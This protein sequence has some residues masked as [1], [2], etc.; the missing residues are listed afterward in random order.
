MAT[1]NPGMLDTWYDDYLKT[2]PTATKPEQAQTTSWN[3]DENQTVQGQLK[4]MLNSGSPL[5]KMAATRAEQQA[6]RRG[7]QGSSMA[8]QA[9]QAA[10]Y[11]AAVPIAT[12]DAATYGRAGEVNATQANETSRFNTGQANTWNTADADRRVR[13]IQVGRELAQQESQFSRNMDLEGRKLDQQESQF[14]RNLT[15]QGRQADL[16]ANTQLKVAGMN[17]DIEDKRLSV[18]D[19]QFLQTLGLEQRKLDDSMD[20]FAKRLGLDRA[21]LDLEKDKLSSQDRQFYDQLKLEEN[22][23]AQQA[24]QFNTEWSNRFSLA[25]MEKAG[26]LELAKMDADNRLALADIEAKYK[27]DIAADQ[28][29]SNAW[30]T[31]VTEIGKI[32]NNPDLEADAKTTLINNTI[33]AFKGF[34]N[35]WKGVNGGAINVDDLLKFGV[36]NTGQKTDGTDGGAGTE[37]NVSNIPGS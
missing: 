26:K 30:G 35:F 12:S 8:V 37:S 18:Q 10:L 7:L 17:Y 5:M 23:L 24:D 4:G 36:T 13:G 14:G 2:A 6:N 27:T 25:E 1:T 33:S 29:I 20:Q 3:V 21:A 28:N 11:D 31:M 9:G 34:T 22:K 16:Q 32:Q 15:E 19:R